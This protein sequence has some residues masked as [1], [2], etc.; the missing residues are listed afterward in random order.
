MFG[1][2]C[3]GGIIGAIATGILVAP[4]LGG[5]GLVDYTL[6][7]GEAAPG[8]YVMIVQLVTQLKAVRRDAA[9]VGH[10]LG[11]PL[12]AR[13]HRRSACGRPTD[14]EREGLDLTEHGERAYNY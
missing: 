2:H 3:I 14:R 8:D 11:D 6:K 12:Q 1:V 7:P 4:A 10:R 5:V 13:R 9:V